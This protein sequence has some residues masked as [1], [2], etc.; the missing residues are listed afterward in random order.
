MRTARAIFAILLAAGCL[1]A[2]ALDSAGSAQTA[3]RVADRIVARIEGDIITLT[4]VRELGAFQ[5]LVEGKSESDDQL[6]SELIEQWVVNTEATA[7]HFPKPAQAEVERELAR[8]QGQFKSPQAY[9][10]RLAA[11]GLSVGDARDM[12][13][14][15]IYLE[16]YIEYKFRP[17]VQLDS[18][19]VDKYFREELVPELTR[20]GQ[21]AP[22][23][24]DVEAQIREV[25]T[26][27]AITKRAAQWL[28]ETKT[29]LKLAI[30]PAGDAK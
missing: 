26:Q 7:T 1:A 9:A 16:R 8:L 17:T 12:L 29:H 4:D 25:L 23:E 27:R 3:A 24:A 19:D 5:Q 10:E 28:D 22:R 13:A 15:Q 20:K 2:P 11:L 21:P 30:V 18:A 14:R 6:L